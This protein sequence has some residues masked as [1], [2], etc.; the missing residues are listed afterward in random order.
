[1]KKV[2][3]KNRRKR[4]TRNNRQNCLQKEIII[5]MMT[6]SIETKI[7]IHHENNKNC[8]DTGKA[9]KASHKKLHAFFDELKWT[10]KEDNLA[11]FHC[12]ENLNCKRVRKWAE[13]KEKILYF[14]LMN[15]L[16]LMNPL[17]TLYYIKNSTSLKAF[18]L[19]LKDSLYLYLIVSDSGFNILPL[20]K[21]SQIHSKG[22]SHNKS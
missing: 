4:L 16:C 13:R 17:C 5:M 3:T 10:A 14:K 12:L 2:V 20:P 19:Q 1:M 22:C 9:Y 6:E 11:Q 7:S 21:N 8:K 15:A 18:R